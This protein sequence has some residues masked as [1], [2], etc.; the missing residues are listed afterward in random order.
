MRQIGRYELRERIGEGAMAEVWRAHDPSIDRV[1]AIKLLKPELRAQPESAARFL[2]EAKAA[3]ALSH[4]A[5]VTIYDVGEADGFPYIAMELLEGRP[6][7]A[8]LKEE[9][10]L[11]IEQ[12]LAIGA[13][14]ASA[15]SYAHLSGVV[16]RDIK[17]S[18][19]M[20]GRDR[21]SIKILDFGIA[22]VAD[23]READEQ[24]K[25]QYGQILGTPR[26]MSPEQAIGRPLDGRSDLFSVGAVLYEIVTGRHA[27]DGASAAVLA[28]QITQADPA[29]IGSI[30]PACPGGL[31]FI[32]EK[33]LAKRPEKRFADGTELSRAL[34]REGRAY[35]AVK[36]DA[37]TRNRYLPLPVRI[38]LA[39]V[40]VT[41]IAL[42][43]SL[44]A[45]LNRQYRAMERMALASGSSIASFVASNAA[46][47]SVDNAT[48][49]P[50]ERDW[51]PVQ[52]FI[53]AAA[54]D[55]SVRW[56]TMVDGDGIIRGASD[57]KLLGTRY[58]VPQGETV[59]HRQADVTVTD[60]K[61]DDG[62]PGFRF[63]H[64]ILYAGRKFGTIEVSISKTELL[65]AAAT[66][67]NLLIALAALVLA[68][69][70]VVSFT[71]A[72]LVAQPLGRLKG[73]LRDGA[74]GDLDF[75]ISH[76]H[77]GEFGELFDSFNLFATAMQ[78]R[79]AATE[80]PSGRPRALAETIVETGP[81]TGAAAPITT[82]R[83]VVGAR[84]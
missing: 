66:S 63:V 23:G 51:L 72:R 52:A 53:A 9:G 44:G 76:R 60:L 45:V 68:V 17:P 57:P 84:G 61:L 40:A 6:L 4:P 79:L 74:M 25:T 67:R 3:G 29:A 58:R 7:D 20:L 8:V 81:P 82:P 80:R 24:L 47:P 14:L 50:E 46:M 59:V 41:A 12:A 18:N 37:S 33:L 27:F 49:P 36:A 28:L 77:R 70:A 1:L 54:K 75:R 30:A 16:H 65:T 35:E 78:E 55:D 48:L 15:L 71:V 39:M 34:S 2:R 62:R 21:E 11:S 13:Q 83:L 69:V 5:I 22:R 10:S 32:I 42:T 19:I 31:R 64:P 56:M 73:A 43:L 38:T 26:Y